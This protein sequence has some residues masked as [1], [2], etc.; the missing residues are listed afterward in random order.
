MRLIR[1]LFAMLIAMTLIGAPV[2]AMVFMQCDTV[3]ASGSDN[4]PF[5]DQAPAPVPCTGMMP[6]CLDMSGCAITAGLPVRVTGA[7]HKL[8]WTPLTYWAAAD[9]HEGLSVEPALDPPITI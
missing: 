2:Q 1:R 5:S 9:M 7:A 3:A 8:I 4:Q 6:G